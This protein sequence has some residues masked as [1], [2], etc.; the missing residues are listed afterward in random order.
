M[1][2]REQ[3]EAIYLQWVNE[4]LSVGAFAECHGLTEAQA[5]DLITLAR[6]IFNTDHPEA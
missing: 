2:A 3:L 6:D 1:T 4:F 5:A